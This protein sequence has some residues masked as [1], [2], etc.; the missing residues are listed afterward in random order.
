MKQRKKFFIILLSVMLSAMLFGFTACGDPKTGEYMMN[1][2]AELTGLT[3]SGITLPRTERD[4]TIPLPAAIDSQTWDSEEDIGGEQFATMTLLLNSDMVN[5]NINARA[6]R[7]A[8]IAYGIGDL[9]N[10]PV[11]FVDYRVPATFNAND[12]LYIRITSEDTKTTNYYRFYMQV[13]SDVT[14]LAEL[15]HNGRRAEIEEGGANWRLAQEGTLSLTTEDS[16]A[17]TKLRARGNVDTSTLQFAR[18]PEGTPAETE[19][20]FRTLTTTTVQEGVK[21]IGKETVK[22]KDEEGKEIDI[23][24]P[25]MG[26]N[27]VTY[28]N[29][30]E[31]FL[32]QDMF[33]VKVTA[34]NTVDVAVYKFLVSVAR[35]ATIK[36]LKFGTLEVMGKGVP[37]EFWNSSRPGGFQVAAREQ[38]EAGYDIVIET[39]DPMATY[40]Y[41]L[42]DSPLAGQPV[43]STNT[44]KMWFDNV[45]ALAIK[46]TSENTKGIMYYKIKVELL[47]ARFL[48][49]PKSRVYYY[50]KNPDDVHP[51]NANQNDPPE[52][53]VYI[54]FGSPGNEVDMETTAQIEKDEEGNDKLDENN[55]PIYVKIPIKGTYRPKDYY[56]YID[57]YTYYDANNDSHTVTGVDNRQPLT[58]KLN[59]SITNGEYQWYEANSWYGGYGFD[60]NGKILYIDEKGEP[61]LEDGFSMTSGY[62]DPYDKYHVDHFD[63]KKNPS[64]FNG[65]NQGPPH[66]VL[67]GRPIPGAKGDFTGNGTG[68]T[69]KPEVDFRP[70]ITGFSSESHYYWV[71]I[72]DKD[73]GYKVTSGRATIVSERDNRK[74]H[75]FIDVNN[76]YIVDGFPAPFKNVIPFKEKYDFFR[77]PIKFP[78][79][80]PQDPNRNFNF[81]DYSIMTVQAKFYLADGTDWIQN[82][83]NGNLAFEDNTKQA[84]TDDYSKDGNLLVLYYN[85]TNN[86]STYMLDGDSKEPQ[87]A[88]LRTIPTHVVISPSGDHTKGTTKNGY[89][90]LNDEGRAA[91]SIV[92]VD[93]QG[94]FCGFIEL[95]EFRFEGPPRSE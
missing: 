68:V 5:V 84:P 80:D 7:S 25:I 73:T 62:E 17:R 48:E 95:V 26:P 91:N 81:L 42:I 35:I 45:K 83:T 40:Q 11:Y 79:K 57:G 77:I 44:G 70:F 9:F 72:T 37:H 8:R 67:P 29:M 47:A 88:D 85:L 89:P 18:L 36:T 66:Y 53:W 87:G 46:V 41:C 54:D 20:V 92:G 63:E 38:P 49:H 16:R 43:F 31:D 58:F 93:L 55:N 78:A 13:Y 1:S 22:G 59:G 90:P 51:I 64:L 14:H 15:F 28:F 65:G 61:I 52:D 75:H 74:K 3:V 82:W 76:D 69:Y 27:M 23:E 24:V 12:F 86:N 21:E 32:D 33:Y 19:P 34:Q 10:R 56:D 50:W 2:K 71:E 4:R 6:S 30:T 60:A 39:D 94:W